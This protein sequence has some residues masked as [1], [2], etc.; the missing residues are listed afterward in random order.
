MVDVNGRVL[1]AELLLTGYGSF[2]DGAIQLVDLADPSLSGALRNAA[3]TTK[4]AGAEGAA[5]WR[6]DDNKFLLTYGYMRGYRTDAVTGVREEVP[7]LNRHRA[8]ADLMLERPGV[9]RV[10]IEGI[11]YGRQALD[12]NPYRSQS[13]PYVYLMAIAMRQFGS[14]EVVANFENLLDVRQTDYDSLLRP[15]PVVGGR[16]TT[17]VWAPLEGFVANVAVRFRWPRSR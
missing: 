13:K 9:Y 6:F 3:G 5:I 12:D 10:G 8:G 17:D 11:Y 14:V 15:A 7:L 4:I 1:G 2:V 16:W